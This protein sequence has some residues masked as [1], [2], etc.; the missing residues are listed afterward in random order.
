MIVLMFRK[1]CPY[2]KYGR[3]ARQTDRQ[4]RQTG[5]QTD[6]QANRQTNRQAGRQADIQTGRQTDRDW[7]IHH[8]HKTF[9][10][11]CMNKPLI[12]NQGKIKQVTTYT[13]FISRS[14]SSSVGTWRYGLSLAGWNLYAVTMKNKMVASSRNK[15]CNHSYLN[16]TVI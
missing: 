4:G 8:P 14:S 5:R 13:A 15:S 16:G 6:R 9:F 2:K 12:V 1:C 7:A 11:G 10:A 3:M